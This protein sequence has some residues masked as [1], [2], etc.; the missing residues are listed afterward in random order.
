MAWDA[1][2]T[3]VFVLVCI[4]FAEFT[5]TY[6]YIPFWFV[7]KAGMV[8]TRGMFIEISFSIL[9]VIATISYIRASFS[10]PGYTPKLAPDLTRPQECEK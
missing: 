2:L 5:L 1:V 7:D 3:V 4:V 9:L 10:D 6:Y 8:T